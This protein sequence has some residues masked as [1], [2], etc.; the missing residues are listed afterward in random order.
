MID[1]PQKK[2]LYKNFEKKEAY[3]KGF[4]LYNLLPDI[5]VDRCEIESKLRNNFFDLIIFG[6]IHR[7]SALFNKMKKYLQKDKTIIL[8]GEDT[9]ALYP[10]HGYYWRKFKYWF[11]P[12]PHTKFNYYK[13]EWTQD[14]KFYRY[15]KLIPKSL[16]KDFSQNQKI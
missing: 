13:R 10:Y 14:T 6:S 12:R 1:Y 16:F 11:I 7:Q 8:D 15:Y 5:E 2:I 4:T 3:G 9:P